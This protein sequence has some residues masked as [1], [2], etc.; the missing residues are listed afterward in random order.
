MEH[1]PS[2][3][4][5][6]RLLTRSLAGNAAS[7]EVCP[8]AE[9]LATFI[10]GGLDAAGRGRILHHAA[11]CGRCSQ[12]LALA[13]EPPPG[14]SQPMPES[15]RLPGWLTGWRWA[16]PF[17]TAVVVAGVWVVSRDAVQPISR[18]EPAVA[19]PARLRTE[20]GEPE[21]PSMAAAAPAPLETRPPAALPQRARVAEQATPPAGSPAVEATRRDAAPADASATS[22]QAFAVPPPA[23]PVVPAPPPVQAPAP[24]PAPPPAASPSAFARSGG[25]AGG[26]VGGAVEEKIAITPEQPV[27]DAQNTRQ[28]IVL[29]MWRYRGTAIERSL[30]AGR[31]WM[32]EF[33]PGRPVLT[34]AM[35]SP[36]VSWFVGVRGLIV[37]R[38]GATWAVV[39]APADLD[40]VSVEAASDRNA[41]VTLADGRRFTTADGGVT[42][43]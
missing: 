14:V 40:V 10:D 42:W 39:T 29:P 36:D 16:V 27:A 35:P 26:V 1:R 9:L 7:G 3:E 28:A 31:T 8:D 6:D 13:V 33:D 41:T 18:T 17:A 25:V 21:A 5:V 37:R 30:D 2:D 32:I 24:A 4:P 20:T 15:S 11:A 38:T 22:R 43:K 23:T 12:I 19:A 34:A